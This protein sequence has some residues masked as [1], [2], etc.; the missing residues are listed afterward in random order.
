MDVAEALATMLNA[1]VTSVASTF[2]LPGPAVHT[3][4]SLQNLVS[5][6]VMKPVSSAPTLPKSVALAA[7][8]VLNR[9][10]WWPTTNPDEI[11]RKFIDDI[12]VEA[13]EALVTEEKPSGWGTGSVSVNMT[14]V[15]GEPVKSFADL[16]IQPDHIEEHAIKYL[17]RYR[18]A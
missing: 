18:S 6:L 4:N 10:L 12:G 9:A 16:D 17:R 1:P 15:D 13:Y 11:E 3:F 8:A 2:A 7:A 5:S 14:G